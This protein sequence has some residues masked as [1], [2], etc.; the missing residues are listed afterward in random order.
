MRITCLTIPSKGPLRKSGTGSSDVAGKLG[1]ATAETRAK[2][3]GRDER[4][5]D[6]PAGARAKTTFK[7][8]PPDANTHARDEPTVAFV[9]F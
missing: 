8:A 1:D 7:A 5:E 3:R 9:I 2:R 6:A 4:R